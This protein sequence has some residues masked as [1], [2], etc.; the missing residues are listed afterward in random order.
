MAELVLVLSPSPY[1]TSSGPISLPSGPF[2]SAN[3]PNLQT[4]IS[5]FTIFHTI[6]PSQV[7][8]QHIQ[9]LH[10]LFVFLS[11]A[12]S[13][14]APLL[15]PQNDPRVDVILLDR[16]NTLLAHADREGM[17]QVFIVFSG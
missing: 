9:F 17:F 4:T 1:S 11:V 3:S 8:Y 5:P 10:Q 2:N 13:R 7:V 6:L 14:V 12:L 16:V 15:F